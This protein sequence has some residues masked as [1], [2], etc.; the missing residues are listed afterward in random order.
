MTD[1]RRELHPVRYRLAK[2]LKWAQRVVVQVSLGAVLV[3][4]SHWVPDPGEREWLRDA[5]GVIMG[6]AFARWMNHQGVR[7]INPT[8]GRPTR[9]PTLRIRAEEIQAFRESRGSD[10]K[11]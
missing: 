6:V 8:T 4:C 1:I 10:Q 11:G 9:T 7:K 3:V 2:L 5:G